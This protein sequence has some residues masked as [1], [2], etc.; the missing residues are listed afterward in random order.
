[1]LRT[2]LRLAIACVLVVVGWGSSAAAWDTTAGSDTNY[3]SIT[4]GGTETDF[5]YGVTVDGSG[6]VYVTGW[7]TGTVDFGAGDV[8]SAGAYDV[9]VTK[10]NAAGAH[11]WTTTFGG[12]GNDD[13]YGVAVDGSGNVHV[14]GYFSNTVDF[15]AGDVTS[16]GSSDAFITKLNAAGV[17]QW[18]TTLGG[19]GDDRPHSVAVDSA[20][21][22]HVTGYFRGAVDFGAGDVT[23][24]GS[25]DAFVTKYNAAGAHQWTTTFGGT[26]PDLAKGVAVDGSGNVH[27]TGYFSNTVD[28]G[29]GNVTSNGDY[30]VYVTKLNSSGVHQWTTT[31]GGT[32]DDIV[33]AVA[34]DGDSNVHVTGSFQGTVNFGAGD[35]TSAGG[36][37]VLVTKLN[38][39][40]AHQWTT[41]FGGTSGEV[42]FGVA[43]DGSGNVYATGNFQGTVDFGA[44]DVTSAG[45][46]DVFITKLNSS[47]AHQWT[48]TFGGTGYNRAREVALDTAGNVHVTGYFEGT[49]DFGAG[50]VTSAGSADGFV[51][52]L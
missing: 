20:G 32:G 13:G 35:V 30:D 9:F 33:L 18:T 14:T 2:L 1:M 51:V 24:A 10:R 39:S 52:K 6:N 19:T 7:F 12:T 36:S 37:D 16:N 49:V 17:H 47:G 50:D 11:Q 4:F 15:G 27:V 44:G 41:T 22:V 45:L 29:A 8:T 23:S 46:D 38:S 5:S 31:L 34:L 25:A 43:V 40:G 26:G 28:F 21:N 42:G 48:T 3:G